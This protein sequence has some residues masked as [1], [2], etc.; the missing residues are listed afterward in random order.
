MRSIVRA[1]AHAT[2][3]IKSVKVTETARFNV[4]DINESGLNVRARA[5]GRASEWGPG[6]AFERAHMLGA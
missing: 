4:V 1:Y 5:S 2:P 3:L 6:I